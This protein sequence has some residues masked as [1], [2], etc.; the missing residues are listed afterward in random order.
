MGTTAGQFCS[1]ASETRKAAQVQHKE[2]DSEMDDIAT[3]SEYDSYCQ[4]IVQDS[5]EHSDEI[6]DLNTDGDEDELITK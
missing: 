4:F 6:F 5:T 2:S 1:G 3:S